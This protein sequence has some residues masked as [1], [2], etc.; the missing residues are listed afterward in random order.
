MILQSFKLNSKSIKIKTISLTLD[1][2]LKL[3]EIV[4]DWNEDAKKLQTQS[5]YEE[6]EQ[7]KDAFKEEEVKAFNE[8]LLEKYVVGIEIIDSKGEFF[9]TYNPNEAFDKKKFPDNVISIRIVNTILFDA[10][11]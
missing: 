3:F 4:K 7:N 5:V 10:Q 2:L 6:W 9:R 11:R 8:K 1:D